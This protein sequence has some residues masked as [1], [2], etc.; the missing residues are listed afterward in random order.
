MVQITLHSE[1]RGKRYGPDGKTPLTSPAGAMY[2][3]QVMPSTITAPGFGIKPADPN[4]PD[5]V[6]RVGREYLGKMLQRYGGDPAKAWAAY[7]WGPGAVDKAVKANG[8]DWLASAP[9]ETRDYVAQ[10]MRMLGEGAGPAKPAKFDTLAALQALEANPALARDPK[11]MQA[12]RQQ[13][14]RKARLY[15]AGVKA[16]AEQVFGFPAGR[17]VKQLPDA[18]G[19]DP[20]G[21]HGHSSL[22][23]VA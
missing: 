11:A 23:L 4:N 13:L 15:D 7:N 5:D 19:A 21:V 18:A 6:A 22:V 10:N 17:A 20:Y 16:Q 1:S 9:K 12:A 2:E 8:A 3:M 14:E